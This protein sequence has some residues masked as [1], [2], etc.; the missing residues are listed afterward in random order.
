[1]VPSVRPR[2]ALLVLLGVLALT[3]HWWLFPHEGDHRYT[4]ERVPVT[5]EEGVLDYDHR[6]GEFHRKNDLVAVGCERQGDDGGGRACAFDAYLVDHGPVRNVSRGVDEGGPSFV[7]LADGY[8][9]RVSERETGTADPARVYDVEPVAPRD[10][11]AEVALNVS[12]SSGA[13][14]GDYPTRYRVAAT[15]EAETTFE[16]LAD[17]ELG[18]VYRLEGRH[19]TVVLT[20]ETRLD[21]PLLT[22]QSRN[23]LA[24]AGLF[25]L[26]AASLLAFDAR[27]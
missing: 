3:N 4:Y 16:E 15:G 8:Y 23:L 21:R 27:R 26:L 19:Y 6:T 9:H 20:A 14:L 7:H 24:V 18:R 13:D 1:M 2:V 10:L 25:S 22:P 5:V 17:D 12:A 11:L